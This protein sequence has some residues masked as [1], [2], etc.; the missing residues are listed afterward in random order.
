MND[1]P[2]HLT[3]QEIL[4]IREERL[5]TPRRFRAALHL[6]RCPDCVGL[7]KALPPADDGPPGYDPVAQALRRLADQWAWPVL[8]AAHV[9]ALDRADK[10][11]WGFLH[12]LVEEAVVLAIYRQC[13]DVFS[14]PVVAAEISSDLVRGEETAKL[15]RRTLIRRG[16]A[17]AVLDFSDLASKSLEHAMEIETGVEDARLDTD[18]LE[19]SGRWRRSM[20]QGWED[21]YA[22][23]RHYAQGSG[24]RLREIEL[25]L[26]TVGFDD[27]DERKRSLAIE[28]LEQAENTLRKI[29]KGD[30]L[31]RRTALLLVSSFAADLTAECLG[32]GLEPLEESAAL[33]R[34]L[35]NAKRWFRKT[36]AWT[37]GRCELS[38]GHLL[39]STD[40]AAA[41][42]SYLRSIDAYTRVEAGELATRAFL[43]LVQLRR[44]QGEDID[45]ATLGRLFIEV[46]R[47]LA[48]P[49]YHKFMSLMETARVAKETKLR[50]MLSTA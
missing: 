44:I 18:L 45:G 9:E 10:A 2:F 22:S 29:P 15:L 31:R 34:K 13:I 11:R 12:V 43:G 49:L 46:E 28:A 40:A 14:L 17:A 47:H 38:L 1:A 39:G 19:A 4:A 36:D 41:Q 30:S 32:Q 5:G 50:E 6:A 20:G 3:T 25:R 37:K 7:A 48:K 21:K 42:K 23:A 26:M 8:G 33:T 27:L 24:D 35:E 16:Y